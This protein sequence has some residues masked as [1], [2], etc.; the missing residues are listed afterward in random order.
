M[1]RM[2]SFRGQAYSAKVMSFGGKP[3]APACHTTKRV[4]K[5]EELTYLSAN[6]AWYLIF[7][8]LK[9]A[10]NYHGIVYCF[11]CGPIL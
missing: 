10:V 11:V 9:L 2:T 5:A 8:G 7:P 1:L 3:T 4:N 6:I